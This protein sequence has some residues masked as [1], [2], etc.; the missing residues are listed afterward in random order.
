[1]ENIVSGLFFLTLGV[2]SFLTGCSARVWAREGPRYR[3]M[4]IIFG[5]ICIT[6]AVLG[7]LGYIDLQT[8]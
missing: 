6:M 2:L 8:D 4:A 7:M 5:L 3:I 1:M